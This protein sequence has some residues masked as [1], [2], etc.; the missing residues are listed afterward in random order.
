MTFPAAVPALPQLPAAT[1][2]DI[3]ALFDRILPN[4]YLAPLKDPGPGYEYLQAVALM[5][6]RVSSAISRSMSG[7]YIGSST[8]GSYA[9]VTVELYRDSDIFRACTL[10]GRASA[11]QGTLVGTSDGY[12]Y[13]IL[14][15]VNFGANDLGPYT[16]Q[17]RATVRGWL[18]NRPGPFTTADGEQ[19][20]GAINR[21]VLPVY[22][23]I[24]SPPNF[25]PTIKV[26]QISA[27]V[28]GSSPMLDAM[29]S[30]RGIPRNFSGITA[31]QVSRS[32][33]SSSGALLPNS[34]FVTADG[35]R[36]ASTARV[37]FDVGVAGPLEVPVR[38]LFLNVPANVLPLVDVAPLWEGGAAPPL[39]VTSPTPV[40]ESDA[41]Y[42]IRMT[43][44]SP[45][46]TPAAIKTVL[47]KVLGNALSVAG[48]T[49]GYRE[50]WDF[51]F[52]TAYDTEWSIGTP[53]LLDEANLNVAVPPF[54]GAVFVYDHV[55]DDAL[56][57]RYLADNPERGVVLIRLPILPPAQRASLYP[58]VVELVEQI[59]PA[60]A[61]VL[62]VLGDS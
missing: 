59:K 36:Y 5:V 23:T 61:A 34:I 25:D 47:E 56:S 44:L 33:I 28:G 17:A 49:W 7:S 21:L 4:H 6:S 46:V 19:I 57:N 16:V 14:T 60:G 53:D 35:F 40:M 15:D 31:A 43:M 55:P 20:E 18:W 27:A 41:D 51:R 42:K 3:L 13:Q 29:G 22:P 11:P 30:D 26:R 38:P 32:D 52:Q 54:N 48:K 8:G 39:T 1:Q 2:D 62:Y 58:G 45:T 50:T 9:E 12:Y 10:L 24:P 37:A